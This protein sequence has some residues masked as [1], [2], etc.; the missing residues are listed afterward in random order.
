MVTACFP[1]LVVLMNEIMYGKLLSWALVHN[2]CPARKSQGC[3]EWAWNGGGGSKTE[4][5]YQPH[6]LFSLFPG[7]ISGDEAAVS[8]RGRLGT[9]QRESRVGVDSPPPNPHETLSCP[10]CF[11]FVLDGI[12]FQKCLCDPPP[13][14]RGAH[15]VPVSLAIDRRLVAVTPPLT[16]SWR[17]SGL[18]STGV[19]Q[20]PALGL[21]RLQGERPGL[22][23]KKKKMPRQAPPLASSHV[24]NLLSVR[25]EFHSISK[26]PFLVGFVC[27]LSPTFSFSFFP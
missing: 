2:Q 1:G 24:L 18:S 22:P 3:L 25:R 11:P 4:G 16:L 15:P 13:D 17:V 19:F 10:F 8:L 21:G 14:L 6:Y 26:F 20:I 5:L 12:Y 27:W 7:L 9:S 23:Q